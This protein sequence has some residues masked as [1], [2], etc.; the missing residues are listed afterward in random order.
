M[1]HR[2]KDVFPFRRAKVA[3]VPISRDFYLSVLAAKAPL[4]SLT[5]VV[6][7]DGGNGRVAG[8]GVPLQAGATKQDLVA[9]LARGLYAISSVDQKTVLKLRVFSKEEAGFDG[10]SISTSKMAARLNEEL[11]TRIRA[12]WTILQATFE[13]YDPDLYPALEF[14]L[15]VTSR[16]AELT[17]GVIADPLAMTYRMP[18]D[19]P[20]APNPGDAFNVRDFVTIQGA[21]PDLRTAGLLKFSHPE[22][23]LSNVEPELL[24]QAALFLLSVAHGVL[25]GKA[26]NS[27]DKLVSEK[28][29]IVGETPAVGPQWDMAPALE[30]IPVEKS[31][32]SALE[33]WRAN[34]GNAVR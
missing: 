19:V 10:N 24:D 2:L 16:L 11:K 17:E 14:V 32:R 1:R 25:K 18:E 30:L 6:M 23:V 22:I 3:P 34:D 13:A 27:G 12:T 31:M 20:S 29:W 21:G 8:M 5:D 9:P 4:P 7:P 28:S 33:D 26:L 15:R